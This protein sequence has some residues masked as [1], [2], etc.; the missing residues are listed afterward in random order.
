MTNIIG[1]K[2]F[3]I[4]GLKKM[5][6][7]Y[8]LI[9]Y[10]NNNDEELKNSVINFNNSDRAFIKEVASKSDKIKNFIKDIKEISAERIRNTEDINN[11]NNFNINRK[12]KRESEET[13]YLL[14]E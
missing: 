3:N 9:S 7:Q 5:I 4:F 11:N 12:K 14:E 6:V 2:C 1:I 10:L 13:E 8:K